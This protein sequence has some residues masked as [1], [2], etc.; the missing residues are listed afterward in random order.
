MIFAE[1][2]TVTDPQHYRHIRPVVKIRAGAWRDAPEKAAERAARELL[3]CRDGERCLFLDRLQWLYRDS[4]GGLFR[5]GDEPV[6]HRL[7]NRFILRWCGHFFT[8][9]LAKV[10]PDYLV[11]QEEPGHSK[12]ARPNPGVRWTQMTPDERVSF[13]RRIDSGDWNGVIPAAMRIKFDP[14]LVRYPRL[15]KLY[16]DKRFDVTYCLD[17]WTQW[18]YW[19]EVRYIAEVVATYHEIAGNT[20]TIC[21][22]FGHISDGTVP[23]SRHGWW[24]PRGLLGYASS[25]EFYVQTRDEAWRKRQAEWTKV[26]TE[27]VFIGNSGC[28]FNTVPFFAAPHFLGQ[29]DRSIE[30]AMVMDNYGL[31]AV[32]QA[33]RYPASILFDEPD[34]TGADAKARKAQRLAGYRLVDEVAAE[35]TKAS[36]GGR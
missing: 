4:F 32:E 28:E 12:S 27:S 8:A 34:G 3:Q 11:M 7:H 19:H 17:A 2:L 30:G 29:G 16:R 1:Q 24:R 10:Q 6:S 22:N 18:G 25:P 5:F 31:L 14:E 36:E 13:K 21:C 9:L 23:P 35:V 33:C 15:D 26:H 20:D